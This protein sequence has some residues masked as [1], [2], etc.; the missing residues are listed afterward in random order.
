MM[1]SSTEDGKPLQL[2]EKTPDKAESE[3]KAIAC[4]GIYLRAE[5][6]LLLRFVEQ[7]PVSE[8]TCQFLEWVCQQ[9]SDMGKRVMPLIWDHATWHVSKQVQQWIRLVRNINLGEKKMVDV[10]CQF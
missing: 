3:P 8:I 10:F 2:V 9:V 5:S 7:R 6:Q 4:Y 1:H